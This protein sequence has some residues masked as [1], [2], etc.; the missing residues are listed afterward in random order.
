MIRLPAGRLLTG[1]L[2][3]LAC[4][5][6]AEDDR[7]AWQHGVN[8]LEVGGKLLLVWGSAGNPPRPNPG[9]AW[10][11][12]VYYAWLDPR[13]QTIEVDPQ[14]LVSLPEAQEPPSVAV[15][16]RGTVLMTSED[17]NGGINQ[18]AGLWDSS[19]RVLRKY[20]FTIRRGGHSGHAA[21]MGTRFLV[22]Y[23]E[24][25]VQG[26]G[27]NGLGT[28][29]KVF[30]RIVEDDGRLGRELKLTPEGLSG[31]RDG[32]PLVA[33][34]DRNWLAVWQRYPSL[35]LQSALVDG[36]GKILKRTQIVGGMPLR[37]AYDVTYAPQLSSYVVA[38]SSGEGGFIA[39]V[40]LSGA[41]TRLQQGLPPMASE[42]RIVLAAEGPD[43][44]AVYPASPRG[45][46]VVRLSADAIA[47][48][49]VVEHPH[50]WDYSG[51]AGAVVAP[52]RVL[53][54]TLSP[55][56]LQLIAFDLNRPRP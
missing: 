49:K 44:L 47:L 24:G 34:S 52:G 8:L 26:G 39:L 54:A 15:N 30:A 32:W 33:G 25:W 56:G 27:W 42:S 55:D 6:A 1:L 45:I 16:S 31:P 10:P 17:G 4:S 13:A 14:V 29:E 48:S 20:P 51:T 50:A 2:L 40:S 22:T 9:G 38:G 37:Y 21:A 53:F 11:H 36:S 28:G 12:D 7:R 18:N 5:A 41:V 19:L 3:C 23:S 35:T 43:L 46:A